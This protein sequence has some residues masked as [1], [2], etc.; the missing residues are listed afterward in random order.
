MCAPGEGVCLPL[1]RAIPRSPAAQ[2][3]GRNCNK[4]MMESAGSWQ[5]PNNC[6]THAPVYRY[7]IS[8]KIQDYSGSNFATMFDAEARE[9]FGHSADEMR[10]S[11]C[12]WGAGSVS[13][14]VLASPAH[15]HVSFIFRA[16]VKIP[17]QPWPPNCYIPMLPT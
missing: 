1:A 8:C 17:I 4:K 6:A 15:L 3:E 12:Q 13:L 7:I 11:E 9:L 5:C 10:S 16:H 2:A 14:L